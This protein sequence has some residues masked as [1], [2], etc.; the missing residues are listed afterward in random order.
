MRS[1]ESATGCADTSH[2][3]RWQGIDGQRGSRG[4]QS[5][6]VEE[7]A[8]SIVDPCALEVRVS[9]LRAA[10]P[11]VGETRRGWRSGPQSVATTTRLQPDS[12]ALDGTRWTQRHETTQGL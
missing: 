10:C 8:I 3:T 5:G 6:L 1:S 11:Q 7:S 12:S 2:A 9:G 4:G